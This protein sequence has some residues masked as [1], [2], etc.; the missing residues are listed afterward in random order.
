M[1]R[2]QADALIQ[3][4]EAAFNHT[5]PEDTRGI[6]IEKLMT[7]PL[8]IGAKRVDRLIDKSTFFPK[9]SELMKPTDDEL[10]IN[11]TTESKWASSK[12]AK[13]ALYRTRRL[14][15]LDEATYLQYLHNPDTKAAFE[16]EWRKTWA[17]E[18]VS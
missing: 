17:Q 1:S 11:T 8:S 6:Y 7:L 9:I 2:E 16:E 10:Q 18:V 12:E 5:L 4:L 15:E 3:R 13:Y 14:L